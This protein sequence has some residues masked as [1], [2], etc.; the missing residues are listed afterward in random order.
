MRLLIKQKV[1]SFK[2][3]YNIYNEDQQVVFKVEGRFFTLGAKIS[4]SD[5]DG[6]ELYYIEQQLFTW[7]P[8]YT[9]YKGRQKCAVISQRFSLIRHKLNVVSQYGSLDLDGDFFGMNFVIYRDHQYLGR[10]SKEWFAWGDTYVLDVAPDQDAAFFC[11]LVI[12]I[13]N[14]LHNGSQY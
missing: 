2:D 13:D 5:P 7:L 14:C 8:K 4:L 9:I 11:A 1:F 10:I 6:N 3:K 12:A